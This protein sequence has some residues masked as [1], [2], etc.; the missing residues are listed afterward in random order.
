MLS[1]TAASVSDLSTASSVK[2]PTTPHPTPPCLSQPEMAA[3]IKSFLEQEMPLDSMELGRLSW[4]EFE[5]LRE[6]VTSIPGWN[7]VSYV[8]FIGFVIQIKSLI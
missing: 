4:E 3:A 5:K 8:V 7:K 1:L 6:K 2:P